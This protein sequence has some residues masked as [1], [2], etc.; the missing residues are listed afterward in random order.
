LKEEGLM[1]SLSTFEWFAIF[2]VAIFFVS[3]TVSLISWQNRLIER[4]RNLRR[5]EYEDAMK[6]YYTHEKEKEALERCYEKGNLYYLHLIPDLY[7]IP[8]DLH[9]FSAQ[10]IDRSEE[11]KGLI[12]RDLKEHHIITN[13]KKVA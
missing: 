12:S 13:E 5:K 9:N 4:E 7:S 8:G 11:R 3:I 1:G 10:M 6:Y 2:M